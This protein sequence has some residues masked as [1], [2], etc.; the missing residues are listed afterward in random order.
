VNR[1]RALHAGTV[2]LLLSICASHR[3][4]A[5][6]A[7]SVDPV[8]NDPARTDTTY[9]PGT[10]ELWFQSKGSRVNGFMYLAQGK[11]PHPTII[12]LHGFPG[13]ERNLDLAQAFRRAGLNVLYFDYRGSWGSAGTFSF[14]HSLE[15]V[16]S[17]VAF[18]RSDSSVRRYR[19]DPRR[20]ILVGHSMGGWL[21]LMESAA[22]SSLSCSAA[23]DFWNVGEDGRRM[24]GDR[25]LDSTTTAYINSVTEPGAPLRAE[26]GSALVSEMKAHSEDWD[27]AHEA[28]SLRARR[29][30][31]VSTTRNESHSRLVTALR[32][33]PAGRLTQLQ[34]PTDHGFSDRRI[35]LARTLLRW[36]RQG[37]DVT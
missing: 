17:A 15:D 22:D 14:A 25:E 4:S 19:V 33:G 23:L 10:E 16:A 9:P 20:I 37:C 13:N 27:P 21:T 5:Q 7:G 24:P 18:V 26:S 6:R 1:K 8:T 30:L 11:G 3:V 36:L 32:G 12:L 31:L 29:L 2:A 35:R 34:W 28:K